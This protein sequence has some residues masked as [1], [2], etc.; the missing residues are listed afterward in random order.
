MWGI[1]PKTAAFELIQ[2]KPQMGNLKSSCITVPTI[3]GSV[4]ATYKWLGTRQQNY[5]IEMPAN[6]GGELIVP[7]A[8]EAV[9]TVN[10]Q[11][12]NPAFKSIKLEP[13][14]NRVEI[15]INSF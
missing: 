3:K 14:M 10:G 9:V 4:K 13:G 8:G 7:D 2:I 6:V 5:E 15:V 11:K 1:T 12:V